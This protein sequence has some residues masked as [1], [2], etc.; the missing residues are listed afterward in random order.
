MST[1]RTALVTGANRGLGRAV[2]AA[3]HARGLRVVLAGRDRS[4]VEQAAAELGAGASGCV[5]D[6]TDSTSV[7]AARALIGPVD[8][9]V[10][11]AGVLLDGGGD[12]LTV[13][14]DL[15]RDTLAVNVLGSWR[16]S[17][18]FVPDMVTRGWGR[19]V[20][21][22]S[23]TGSFSNGLFT[24]APGYSVSKTALN[25]LTTMLAAQTENT[26]VL[27]NAVNPGPTR[28]R[29]M[30]RAER[31]PEEAGELIADAATLPDD[32]PSGRFLRGT[33]VL[34]W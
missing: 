28:T 16:V 17:Q 25:G 14:L 23:G 15:V 4:S 8:V 7:L 1:G 12:P 5:L 29:M 30:P 34:P 32:G 11:N 6:V 13:D 26:G 24:G 10:N 18:A 21:V 2:A 27:V 31:S 19:V 9:L 20:I 3:L 22:S 33:Q